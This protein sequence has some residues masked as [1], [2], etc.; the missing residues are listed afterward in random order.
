M[1][2]KRDTELLI[3][4]ELGDEP[5]V[6]HDAGRAGGGGLAGYVL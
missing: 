2:Y 6:G 5:Q 3:G 4:Q 1:S